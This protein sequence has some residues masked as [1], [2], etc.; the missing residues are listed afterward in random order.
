MTKCSFKDCNQEVYDDSDKCILHCEK[1][2]LLE[3]KIMNY[4]RY[5]GFDYSVCQTV[6]RI[7][8]TEP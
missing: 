3:K 8:Q 6:C 4:L 7:F 2:D 1:D 5:R